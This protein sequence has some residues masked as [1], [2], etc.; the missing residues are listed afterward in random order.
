M[1]PTIIL[2][3][4]LPLSGR[5]VVVDATGALVDQRTFASAEE[6]IAAAQ[7]MCQHPRLMPQPWQIVAV[8]EPPSAAEMLARSPSTAPAWMAGA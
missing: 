1:P 7:D 5:V 6:A 3:L 2:R 4:P 8:V